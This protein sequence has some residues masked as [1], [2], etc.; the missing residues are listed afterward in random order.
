LSLRLRR[1][2]NVLVYVCFVLLV[3]AFATAQQSAPS[4]AAKSPAPAVGPG[5]A[6]GG[7]PNSSVLPVASKEEQSRLAPLDAVLKDAVK[8]G[9]A[10]GAVLLVGHNGLI[11]YQKAYGNRTAGSNPEAMTADTIFDLASLTKVIATTTCVMRLEQLGQIKLNDPVAKY[12]PDFAQN[13]KQ[14]V[15]IR[16]L[17]THYSG[18]PADLDLKEAW[19][20]ADEGYSRANATKL[21]NPPGSTFLYSD[22]GFVVLGELVQKVGGMPLDQYAQ[23]YVFGPLGMTSTRFNPPTSWGPRIAPTQ[24]DEHTGQMVRGTVH[25][26][27]AHQM[28]GVAGDAGVFSTAED[29]AKFA[30]A[31][32]NRGAPILSPLIVEKMT[33]PQQPSNMPNVRG[34][35]WDIDSPFSSTR[36]ELLPVGSFGH[37]GFTG[38]SLWIDATT[39]TYVILLTNSTLLKDGNVIGLRTEIA[40]AV[41]AALQLNPSEEQK[42]RLARITGYNETQMAERRI[43]VRNGKVLTGID[44]LEERQFEPLKVPNVP[45]PHIGLVT[46]QTGVD[47]HGKRTI[48]VL[49]RAP[50]MQLA[51]IFTPEFGLQDNSDAGDAANAKDGA[52]GVPIYSVYGDADAKRRPPLD[53]I[54][55]LDV[56]VFDLQDVGARFSSY[57]STLGYFLDAAAKAKKPIVVLDRPNP[58]TGAYVQGPLSDAGQESYVNYYPLPVRHGMTIGELAKLFNEEKHIDADLT[59][60]PMRGWLRGDWFDS[61]GVTWVNPAPGI[62]S[63]DQATLYP[64]VAL[65]E[66]TSV[67]VGRGTDLPFQLVGSPYLTA[68]ELS[69]YLNGRNIPG[70]RFVPVSFTPTS[71]PFI[72]RECFGVNIIVTNR[73]ELDAPELGLEL[74]AAL[75]KLSP[76]GYDL[77]HMNQLLANKAVFAALQAG[78]DPNRIAADWREQLDQFMDVRVKYLLY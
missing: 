23:T 54:R 30:Q 7:T 21:V 64:A 76:L 51:A 61:T 63:L 36:G 35:G 6:T 59:V 47:S 11:V 17:L 5:A 75:H 37:T 1:P 29:V 33:T 32:L 46:N 13:G 8:N 70:V 62:H 67:S 15:T 65:I 10:P 68:K 20:G 77:S 71:G 49:A 27:T 43:V 25:D 34:L 14:D 40:T 56:L 41:A 55:K 38:T 53:I 12:I 52:T 39:N 3:T 66:G 26:P 50:G 24:R 57:E 78:Q 74:A 45:T 2:A 42:T 72:R 69:S 4:G 19:N 22:V 31:L 18:L 60:V 48:D 28:G 58:I 9:N 44:A 73:E 16:M